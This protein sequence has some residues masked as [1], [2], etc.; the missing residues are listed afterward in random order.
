MRAREC[1][2]LCVY[3]YIRNILVCAKWS[4]S[5]RSGEFKVASSSLSPLI[6]G[7]STSLLRTPEK[8]F[9]RV[10]LSLHYRSVDAAAAAAAPPYGSIGIRSYVCILPISVS[11]AHTHTYVGI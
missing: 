7:S 10:R 6:L 1:S 8:H 9:P 2:V 11:H 5:S 3:I 4:P